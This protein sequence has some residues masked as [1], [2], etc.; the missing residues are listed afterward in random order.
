MMYLCII[1]T[2]LNLFIVYIYYKRNSNKLTI[3]NYLISLYSFSVL[4]TLLNVDE[5]IIFSIK[6]TLFFNIILLL[7][8]IPVMRF[9]GN[10]IYTIRSNQLQIFNVVSYLFIISGI[11]AIIFFLPTVYKLFSSN[12]SL[13]VLRTN[14]VGGESYVGPGAFYN[15]S[16]LISQF[17]PIILI[18][19][20]YSISFLN[21]SKLFNFLL[22]LSSTSYIFNVLSVV[23]RDGFI[24]W[25]MSYIFSFL[26]FR[27]HISKKSKQKHIKLLYY[28]IGVAL[29]FIVPITIA[30]FFYQGHEA[31]LDSIVK[32]SGAQF[33]NFNNFFNR[34]PNPEKYGSFTDIFPIFNFNFRSS[35]VI[36]LDSWEEKV[37]AFGIDTNVF[38]TFIGSFY[39]SIGKVGTFILGIVFFVLGYL[40][41]KNSNQVSLSKIILI[42]LFAQIILHGF[43]YYKLAYTVSNIY[44]I[45]TVFL[46]LFFRKTSSFEK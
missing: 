2:L 14:M 29:L 34:I 11:S 18:F 26:L 31:G 10:N 21:K 39:L 44:M 20:F 12:I 25:L 13:L 17:Y 45:L 37:W 35:D 4:L 27:N 19:Y 40:I 42:T 41:S 33:A 38:S 3:G 5:T 30:R 28:T 22:L 24:L 32:Y 43:F 36:F 1:I 15:I 23:G 16:N 6:A 8:I 7:F 9:K 46:S